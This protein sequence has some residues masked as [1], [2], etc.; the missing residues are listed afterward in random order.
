MK[1]GTVSVLF[2]V[3]SPIHSILVLLSWRILYGSWPRFW[4]GVCIFLHDVGH[5]GLQYLDS[6]EE[7]RKHWRRGAE[8]ARRLFG[9]KGWTMCAGH[10]RSSGYSES[11]LYKADKYSWQIAPWIWL[12]S[13][14]IVEPKVSM[15]YSAP[16]AIRLF[17]AQVKRSID[18]GEFRPTHEF[19]L[20]RCK[21]SKP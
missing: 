1:Q 16:E 19:F 14:C 6:H 5:W 13:N 9:E 8:I 18:S 17:R 10:D 4:E 7:K 21:N 11:P 3:H 12:Y 2:G 20:D 15:G